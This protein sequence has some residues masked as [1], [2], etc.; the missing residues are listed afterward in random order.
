M[1]T[2]IDQPTLRTNQTESAHW[3]RDIDTQGW[4]DIKVKTD[5]G[6]TLTSL[7]NNA[8]APLTITAQKR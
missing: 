4:A 8:G 5:S 2:A 6:N 7:L 3:L 1:D